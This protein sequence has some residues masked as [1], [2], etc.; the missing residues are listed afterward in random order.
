MCNDPV[1]VPAPGCEPGEIAPYS[2]GFG[3]ENMRSITVTANAMRVRKIIGQP[4][5]VVPLFDD[6]N[7]LSSFPGQTFSD[8]AP[9]KSRSNNE[10]IKVCAHRINLEAKQT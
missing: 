8:D 2:S 4:S 1:F 7:A 6:A 5:D 3:M 10:C 9:G